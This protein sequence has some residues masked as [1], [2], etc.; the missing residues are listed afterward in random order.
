MS[1]SEAMKKAAVEYKTG[2]VKGGG[3]GDEPADTN[4]K[5]AAADTTQTEPAA[6]TNQTEPAAADTNTTGGNKKKNNPWMTF[7]VQYRKNHPEYK[8]DLKK[9]LISASKEY[10]KNSK[11]ERAIRCAQCATLEIRL[12]S[13]HEMN[14]QVFLLQLESR[15]AALDLGRLNIAT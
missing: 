7:L 13:E 8:H 11:Q 6:D 15:F 5:P 14:L 2:V 1:Y 9:M 10:K 3:D 4:T 12:T